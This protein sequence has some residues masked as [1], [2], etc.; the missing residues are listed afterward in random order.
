MEI[1]NEFGVQPLLLLAQVV[2]FLILLF[3]LKKFLYKPILNILEER[4]QK[5]TS[6]LKN[7]EEIEK[8]LQKIESERDEA[9]KKASKEA[10]ELLQSASESAD[11]IIQDA[12]SKAQKDIQD[13]VKKTKAVLDAERESLHKE[14]RDEIADIVVASLEKIAQKSLSEKEKQEFV[15]KSIKEL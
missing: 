13:L 5:I 15:Q 14:I 9:L 11:Q 7:A 10:K 2:N 8:R 1:F 4:K 6:S 12:H 3:I